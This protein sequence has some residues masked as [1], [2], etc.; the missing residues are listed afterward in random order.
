MKLDK[1]KRGV[2]KCDREES[3]QR[4]DPVTENSDYVHMEY[5]EKNGEW[6]RYEDYAELKKEIAELKA[7]TVPISKLEEVIAKDSFI[8]DF[9]E[10]DT[11]WV[12]ELEDLQ[13]LIKEVKG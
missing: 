10:Y 7:T 3:V 5:C 8:V 11:R 6:V 2:R 9:A 12:V 4:Y 1:L 13:V